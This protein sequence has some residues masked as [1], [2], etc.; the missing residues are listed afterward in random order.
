MALKKTDSLWVDKL[1]TG[2]ATLG[3][4]LTPD[5]AAKLA[6]FADRL[7]E[8]G[9]KMDLSSIDD[10]AAIREKHFLDSIAGAR[11]IDRGAGSLVDLGSGGG[12]PGLVLAILDP[13]LRVLSVESRSKKGVFQR[14][15]ARDLA[16]PNF[17][18]RTA[19]I[20][21]VVAREPA[22]TWITARALADVVALIELAGPWLADGATLVAWKSSKL[23]EEL[24]A[25]SKAL[26][27]CGLTI[28]RRDVF[29]L[30]E[31]GDPRTLLVLRR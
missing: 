2:A 3:I 7:V 28:A 31:S 26:A 12:F 21:D 6:R 25:A 18:A 14:Q 8:W 5:T 1:V 13:A 22:P 24:V 29:S 17:E 19:R 10:L 27:D 30:P 9:A 16:L 23:D 11:V 20:E 15:V 4:A